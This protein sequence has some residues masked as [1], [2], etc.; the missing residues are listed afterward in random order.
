MHS[1][2]DPAGP[3]AALIAR[4]SWLLIAG[5]GAI[6]LAVM[7][8]MALGLRRK[9]GAIRAA[10]W[11]GGGV[12]LPLVVLTA[13][14]VYST[15]RSAQLTDQTSHRAMVVSVTAKMWWWEVRYKGA[16]GEDVVLANELHIP[17]GRRVYLAL[18]SS[19]VIHSL[20]IP[21]LAG[22][23]DML[24]GRVNGLTVLAGKPGLYLGQC[25]E[26]CGEQHARMALHVVAEP[27]ADFDAWLAR[28]ALP[29]AVPLS[30]PGDAQIDTGRQAFQQRCAAC[31]AV[32]GP[33]RGE[34]GAAA[35][36]GGVS[37]GPDL[38][39]VGSRLYLAGGT[40][41]NSRAA[42]AKWIADPQAHKPG[43]RMPA[44]G[45]DAATIEALAAY[46]E[47]LK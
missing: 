14:Y 47:H 19:D 43:A 46:L 3:D 38:T 22:K 41:A 23:V 7:V 27:P 4:M 12:L 37:L 45:M 20:W 32:R 34:G 8:L 13:L 5:A 18:A 26:Y 29:A 16:A 24:P 6:F 33:S 17:V 9:A 42:L 25:A 11:L 39:H 1:V 2:L 21:A 36:P 10:W 15:W 44:A 35:T 31:H 30:A 40:L 28:Q